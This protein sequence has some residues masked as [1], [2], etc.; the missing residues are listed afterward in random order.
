M[1]LHDRDDMDT[2]DIDDIVWNMALA[3]DFHGYEFPKGTTYLLAQN[4]GWDQWTVISM[5]VASARSVRY[6]ME[7]Y[8]SW[9]DVTGKVLGP[10]IIDTVEQILSET[11]RV[12]GEHL[13]KMVNWYAFW[14]PE[15][16]QKASV[17]IYYNPILGLNGLPLCNRGQ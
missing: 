3:Q 13:L 5:N 17:A 8:L 12:P 16:T 7:D 14:L 2:I 4:T 15:N 11:N 10:L 6:P 9:T 1:Y